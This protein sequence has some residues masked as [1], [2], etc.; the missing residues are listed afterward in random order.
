MELWLCFRCPEI[1]NFTWNEIA[2]EYVLPF[3]NGWTVKKKQSNG[4]VNRLMKRNEMKWMFNN[5]MCV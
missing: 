2:K 4:N 3:F 1:M 5:A